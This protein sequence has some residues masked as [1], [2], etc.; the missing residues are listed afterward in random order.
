MKAHDLKEKTK[1]ELAEVL[2]EK[3]A[4]IEELTFLLSQKKVKNV[5]EL[6]EAKKDVAR[7]LTILN[8]K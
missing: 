7:I 3:R 5:K 2:Q 8:R 1:E 4:R 6:R